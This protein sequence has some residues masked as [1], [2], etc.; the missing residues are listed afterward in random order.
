MDASPSQP[1]LPEPKSAEE[2]KRI[3]TERITALVGSGWRV[4][5]QADFNAVLVKGHRPNHILHLILSLL[6]LFLWA[7]FVWLPICIFGGEKRRTLS[8]DEQGGLRLA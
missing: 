5:S 1:A 4:E 8:V 2:R 3:L 7:I 6:T